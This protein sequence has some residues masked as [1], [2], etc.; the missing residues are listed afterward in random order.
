[1]TTYKEKKEMQTNITKILR[2]NA[3]KSTSAQYEIKDETHPVACIQM[4]T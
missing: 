3:G 4:T 2:Q 1:M